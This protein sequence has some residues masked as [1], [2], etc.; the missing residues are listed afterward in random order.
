MMPEL[1]PPR[2]EDARTASGPVTPSSVFDDDYNSPEP[3][4]Q[5]FYSIVDVDTNSMVI[6]ET[7]EEVA[8]Q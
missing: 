3:R 8:K 5:R 7:E 1:N 4:S 6:E 2:Y